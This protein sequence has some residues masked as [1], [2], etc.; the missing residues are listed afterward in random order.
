[1]LA[2]V[3]LLRACA[4][5][6]PPHTYRACVKWFRNQSGRFIARATVSLVL[7]FR[8]D[9]LPYRGL[10]VDLEIPDGL[11]IGGKINLFRHWS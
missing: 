1:M 2:S 8:Y 6:S 11:P 9:Y 4:I 10:K 3:R 5:E 7:S